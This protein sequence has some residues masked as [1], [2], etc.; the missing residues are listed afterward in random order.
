MP[1]GKKKIKIDHD[2]YQR[3][4]S[5]TVQAAAGSKDN[6]KKDKEEKSLQMVTRK[7]LAFLKSQNKSKKEG[8]C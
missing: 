2:K 7:I 3:R 1:D 4:K 6:D 5:R 8:S